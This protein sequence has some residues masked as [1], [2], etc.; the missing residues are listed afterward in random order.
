MLAS[1]ER[2]AA[3]AHGN[4]ETLEIRR[5]GELRRHEACPVRDRQR[6]AGALILD[7]L[8][9]SMKPFS[10]DRAKGIAECRLPLAVPVRSPVFRALKL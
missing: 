6:R 7:T 8:S 3:D 5:H 10:R 4:H 9:A 1:A 2:P